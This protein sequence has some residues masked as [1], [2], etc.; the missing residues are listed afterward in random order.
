MVFFINSSVTEF[1]VGYLALFHLFS[2]TWPR[3]VVD[4]KSLTEDPV[5]IG[6]RKAQLLALHFSYYTLMNFLML[7][8]ILLPML[9][10]ILST[11]SVTRYLTCGKN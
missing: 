9:M 10:I 1:R 8:V 3:M 11:L 6:F 5:N 7:S 2:V 4:G